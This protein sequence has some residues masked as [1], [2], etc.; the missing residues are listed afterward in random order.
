M[1]MMRYAYSVN[2]DLYFGINKDGK[3]IYCSYNNEKG[4]NKKIIESGGYYDP[5]YL[6]RI[7]GVNFPEP[8]EKQ[9]KEYFE[10]IKGEKWKHTA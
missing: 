6:E 1:K 4:S 7:Q 10:L 2:Y 8:T 5:S 3:T 9:I